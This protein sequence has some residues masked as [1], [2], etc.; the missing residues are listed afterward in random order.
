M[1]ESSITKRELFLEFFSSLIMSFFVTR[2]RVQS[3]FSLL[4][5]SLSQGAE[6]LDGVLSA[7]RIHQRR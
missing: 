6:V 7:A 3:I 4:S 2:A 1:R 5:L